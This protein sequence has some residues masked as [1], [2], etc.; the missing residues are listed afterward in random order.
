MTRMLSR[1][2]LASASTRGEGRGDEQEGLPRDAL[3]LRLKHS[4][5]VERVAT[6]RGI[7]GPRRAESVATQQE[8][9]HQLSGIDNCVS[10]DISA[11]TVV[12]KT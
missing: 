10:V 1:L 9:P 4:S 12:G 8:N 3:E 7:G 6:W 5:L 11:L 2:G